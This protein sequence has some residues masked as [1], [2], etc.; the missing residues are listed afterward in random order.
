MRPA[1]LSLVAVLAALL[2]GYGAGQYRARHPQPAQPLAGRV[3]ARDTARLFVSGPKTPPKP[4]GAG[5]RAAWDVPAHDDMVLTP[6][7]GHQQ[8]WDGAG[9][10][11][12]ALGCVDLYQAAIS[13]AA[14]A[15]AGADPDVG[16]DEALAGIARCVTACETRCDVVWP[17]KGQQP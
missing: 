8:T 15:D 2:G 13:A 3:E 17:E 12:C 1:I 16:G 6:R 5:W 11:P 7:S 10:H 4:S 9:R 14:R